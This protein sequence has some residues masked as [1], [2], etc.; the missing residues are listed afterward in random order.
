LNP[1]DSS[2]SLMARI[3]TVVNWV[4]NIPYY[5]DDWMR[6]TMQDAMNVS[7]PGSQTMDMD[8]ER[9]QSMM[10]YKRF[11][12]LMYGGNRVRYGLL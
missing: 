9:N 7:I 3:V 6:I 5:A 12:V 10:L 11:D 8:H 2:A 4:G 1:T